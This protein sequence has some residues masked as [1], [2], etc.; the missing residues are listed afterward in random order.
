MPIDMTFH[1]DIGGDNVDTVAGHI[2]IESFYQFRQILTPPE[3]N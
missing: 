1:I 2:D 3:P